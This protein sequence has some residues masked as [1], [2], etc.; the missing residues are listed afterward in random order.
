MDAYPRDYLAH[1]FPFIVLSGL[2]DSSTEQVDVSGLQDDEAQITAAL[3]SLVSDTA[4]QLRNCFL[5]EAGTE[6]VGK[7]RSATAEAGRIPFKVAVLGRV[8]AID[9]SHS[10]E[11]FYVL[12]QY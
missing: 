12:N 10:F 3:P 11:A 6:D 9:F 8:G 7:R 2:T 4:D 5:Q 1:N